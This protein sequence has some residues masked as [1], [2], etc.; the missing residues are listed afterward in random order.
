MFKWVSNP[1][2]PSLRSSPRQGSHIPPGALN[3]D[4]MEYDSMYDF[5][6]ARV[7]RGSCSS[8]GVFREFL[9]CGDHLSCGQGCALEPLFVKCT[10]VLSR[11][12]SSTFWIN[13]AMEFELRPFPGGIADLCCGYS[14]RRRS[15]LSSWTSELC[16]S[17]GSPPCKFAR[18][19]ICTASSS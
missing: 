12:R 19:R 2:F 16:S 10:T 5:S 17:P 15:F 6:L 11:L 4:H 18:M 13:L 8:R 7:P 1:G 3:G 9:Q 14:A